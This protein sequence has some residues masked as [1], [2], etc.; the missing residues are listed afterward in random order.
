MRKLAFIIGIIGVCGFDA[1]TLYASDELC[2][3]PKCERG[4]Q[5]R[6][7]NITIPR[8]KNV[9]VQVAIPT[10]YISGVV[11]VR[12]ARYIT[13]GKR[14][15]KVSVKAE[16]GQLVLQVSVAKN[17]EPGERI[18]D[19]RQLIGPSKADLDSDDK[20]TLNDIV[21]AMGAFLQPENY[22]CSKLASYAQPAN[23]V[24]REDLAEFFSAFTEPRMT[25]DIIDC[26]SQTPGS[27]AGFR[28]II[29]IVR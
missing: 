26:R 18:L 2:P 6:V 29:P 24:T 4:G 19:I 10:E 9:K 23:T 5:F 11:G 1:F 13:N 20:R 16:N 27:D 12:E 28:V 15:A 14:G 7:A 22:R 25:R 8:K 3:V 17:A 21:L